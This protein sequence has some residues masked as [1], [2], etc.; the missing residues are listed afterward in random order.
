V[1][2]FPAVRRRGGIAII[3]ASAALLATSAAEAQT[4]ISA[5][6]SST[7]SGQPLPPGFV[8]MSVEYGALHDYT[9]R[10]AN[11]I[12][13]LLAPLLRALAPGQAPVLRIGGDSTDHT[14]W[15][16]RGVI[17]PEGVSYTLTDDWLRTTRSLAATLGARLILGINLA[18]ARPAIAATEARALLQGIGRQYV[19][20]LEIGNEPDLYGMFVWYRDRNGRTI[21][22][23]P[24]NWNLGS[25]IVDFSHWRAALPTAPVAGPAFA[26]LD[27]MSSLDEFL[28]HEPGL[29]MVTFHRYPLR[30]CVHNPSE[31]GYPSIPALLSDESSAGLAQEIA[32]YVSLAHSDGVPFRLDELNSVA[33][34]GRSGVS[35][36]FASALWVLD[37]L[38][39]LASVGVDGVNV[40]TL[41]GAAYELFTISDRRGHWSAFVHP[42]YYG[43]TTF[44]QA[45]PAGAQLL[46]VSAPSGPV[47]VWATR[48]TDGTIRVTLINKDATTDYAVTLKLPGAPTAAHG[49][50]LHAPTLSSKSGVTSTPT[51]VSG[52]LG[53]Y[54]VNLP[55]GSAIVVTK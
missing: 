27:W 54:A 12:D 51:T 3:A 23:R 48:S 25:Y 14:W 10:D 30:G 47:K 1:R 39:N 50:L 13:P 8:G 41:P 11:A 44:A 36:T 40:H 5:Q 34:R 29:A 38:F 6:V 45:F 42:E 4:P 15:P 18:T 55:P 16:I 37:T 28:S 31:A 19:T 33:C 17:P 2:L 43:M 35:D 53:S 22:A 20:A 7:A 49:E 46:S 9:G 21:S 24:H 52:G 32:P 26:G